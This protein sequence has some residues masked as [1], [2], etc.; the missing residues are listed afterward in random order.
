MRK[1]IGVIVNN[2]SRGKSYHRLFVPFE[3]LDNVTMFDGI[4]KQNPPQNY[5]VLIFNSTFPQPI[6]VL[7]WCKHQGVKIVIDIDDDIM[8]PKNHINYR[9]FNSE[10]YHNHTKEVI[11]MAD[12]IWCASKKLAQRFGGIYIPNAINYKHSQFMQAYEPKYDIAYTGGTQ[13]MPFITK[14]ITQIPK[15]CTITANGVDPRNKDWVKVI[16]YFKENLYTNG[17]KS[18]YEYAKI[19]ATAKMAIAPVENTLHNS[20]KSPLKILEAAAYNLPIVCSDVEC[21]KGYPV[22]YENW[23]K[24]IIKLKR[25]P[26]LREDIGMRIREYV[27]KH[28]NLEES[29][30]MRW[31]SLA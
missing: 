7:Q 9:L 5:D 13:H 16:N 14:M 25:N 1:R 20:Y 22:L 17:V 24:N 29:N 19:Y 12:V 15:H 30:K 4:V 8:L 6:E 3:G 10:V 23:S 18:E 21:Y 11:K 31:Q 26:S 28:N 2:R 27:D